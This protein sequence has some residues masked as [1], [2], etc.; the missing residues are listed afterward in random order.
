MKLTRKEQLILEI[1][2]TFCGEN[3]LLSIL[4]I[5]KK[6][7]GIPHFHIVDRDTMGKK[8]HCKLNIKN[9]EYFGSNND[10]LTNFDIYSLVKHLDYKWI[11]SSNPTY[12]YWQMIVDA[13]NFHNKKIK[14][15]NRP[16]YEN[17]IR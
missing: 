12:T 4:I 8:F 13:W 14:C 15:K 5:D 3:C 11:C 10:K 2:G 6:H 17:L 1:G 16:K 9:F 7:T